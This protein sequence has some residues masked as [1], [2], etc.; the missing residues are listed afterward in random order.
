MSTAGKKQRLSAEESRELLIDAG[1]QSLSEE[2]LS[3]G[4]DAVNLERAVRA[5][6]VP[7]SSAYAAWSI[8]ESYPPQ[9][10]FQ[11]AVLMRAI[12]ARRE[13][14]DELTQELAGFV[15]NPTPGLTKRELLTEMIR[16][17]AET[18]MRN[19]IRS[20]SWQIVFAMRSIINSAPAESRDQELFEWMSANEEQLRLETI[21]GTYKP[22]AELF[23][24]RPRPE[25]GEKAWHAAEIA[26]AALSEGLSMRAS[27]K[28][29]E[30][31][32]GLPNPEHP[33]SESDW[34]LFA[35]IFE[36]IFD[37]FFLFDDED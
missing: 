33:D 28:A 19:V 25:F 15:E 2:G 4:L 34:T 3:L 14:L 20:R 9:E 11:R 35:L 1:L 29:S 18:N 27:L 30:Y 37:T 7:R 22:M 16:V 10:L 17:A 8:D 32:G 6:T 23:G 5:T 24:I 36:K 31:F 12:E 21:E 26:S 13:T